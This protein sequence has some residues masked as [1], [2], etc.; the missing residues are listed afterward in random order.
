[1]NSHDE[2]KRARGVVSKLARIEWPDYD[3]AR[4]IWSDRNRFVPV[5]DYEPVRI[6]GS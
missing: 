4:A 2:R 6:P 3:R 1:M 5:E